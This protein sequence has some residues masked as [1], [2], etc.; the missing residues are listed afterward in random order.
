MSDTSLEAA[1]KTW[2]D[3]YSGKLSLTPDTVGDFCA[4]N[5]RLL[6]E[7]EG[8]G[9]QDLSRDIFVFKETVLAGEQPSAK[10]GRFACGAVDLL[11]GPAPP[12]RGPTEG[13]GGR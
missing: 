5:D 10:V 6:Q 13:D 1:V 3:F 8:R 2:R 4:A 9:R 11:G 7:A 12:P